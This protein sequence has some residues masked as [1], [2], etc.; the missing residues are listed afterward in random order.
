MH[1]R[2]SDLSTPTARHYI[3]SKVTDGCVTSR[4]GRLPGVH[5]TSLLPVLRFPPF[6]GNA[7]PPLPLPLIVPGPLTTFLSLLPRRLSEPPLYRVHQKKG[8]QTKKNPPIDKSEGQENREKTLDLVS[9]SLSHHLPLQPWSIIPATRTST[10][11][12][13]P[14]MMDCTITLVPPTE[15]PDSLVP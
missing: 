11:P 4:E 15:S 13:T 14:P 9:N 6:H 7:P 2:R 5:P 3:S 1:D 8:K 12:T 10:C